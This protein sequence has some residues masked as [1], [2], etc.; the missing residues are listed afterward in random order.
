MF[1]FLFQSYAAVSSR[2]ASSDS[3]DLR[4]VMAE[5]IP[6]FQEEVKAFRKEHGNKVIGE[7]TVDQVRVRFKIIFVYFYFQRESKVIT[8]TA[9]NRKLLLY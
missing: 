8:L 7:V 3:T 6:A 2:F 5:K 4:K 9:F 1:S